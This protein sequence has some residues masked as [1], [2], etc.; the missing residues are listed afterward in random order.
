[1]SVLD[2]AIV[3]PE[4]LGRIAGSGEQQSLGWFVGWRRIV[5]P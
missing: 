1:M 4:R 2:E 5:L 3:D